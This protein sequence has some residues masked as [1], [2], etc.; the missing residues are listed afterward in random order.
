MLHSSV[1][2]CAN[3]SQLQDI[4]HLLNNLKL[5][6]NSQLSSQ[7]VELHWMVSLLLKS[8]YAILHQVMTV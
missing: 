7:A 3:V 4:L 6:A 5:R 2:G 1:T 8:I